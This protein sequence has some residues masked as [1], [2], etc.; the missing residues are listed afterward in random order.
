MTAGFQ[1]GHVGLTVVDLGR[2][3]RF[4]EQV[5]RVPDAARVRG[6]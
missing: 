6:G 5:F 4:Y 3:R 2:S 1:T